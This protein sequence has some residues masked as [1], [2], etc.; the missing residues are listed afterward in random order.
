MRS[1]DYVSNSTNWAS[2]SLIIG[3]VQ[4]GKKICMHV[5]LEEKLHMFIG[6]KELQPMYQR[7]YKFSESLFNPC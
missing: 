3:F 6:T 5:F 7:I 1:M 2:P 4:N